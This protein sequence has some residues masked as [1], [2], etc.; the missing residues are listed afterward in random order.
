MAKSREQEFAG[1]LGSVTSGLLKIAGGASELTL[2]T[3]EKDSEHLYQGAFTGLVPEVRAAS[4]VV[5]VRYPRRVHP[6]PVRRHSGRLTVN[7]SVPWAVEVDGGAGRLTADL[8]PLTLTG[9]SLGGGASH[10]SVVLPRPTGTVRIRISGGASNVTLRRPQDVAARVSVTGG[11]SRLT[12]DSQHMDAV[13]GGIQLAGPAFDNEEDRY[14]IE[15]I[16]GASA[17]TVDRS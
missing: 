11:V 14:E 7:A 17:L 16:G 4:G 3:E 2:A 6:L 12:F 10:V 15:V 13:G 1:P 8:S 9:L 5:T